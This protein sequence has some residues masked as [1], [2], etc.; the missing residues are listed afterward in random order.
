MRRRISIRS[1]MVVLLGMLFLLG[2]TEMAAAEVGISVNVG[3]PAFVFSTPLPVIVIPGTYVYAVPDI[4]AGLFFYQGY[5]YRPYVGRWYRASS[6]NGPW[7]FIETSRVPRALVDLPPGSWRVSAGYHRIPH[8]E[9]RENWGRWER[10][11]HWD[12]DREWRAG[13]HGVR[14]GRGHEGWG[15]D[16]EE[17]GRN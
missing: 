14:E 11:R 16:P 5:W 7:G 12:R 1:G 2:G 4:D 10:E 3:L 13:W 17:H 6:Y 15:R 8:A 9:L